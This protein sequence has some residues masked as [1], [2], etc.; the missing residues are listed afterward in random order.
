MDARSQGKSPTGS[1]DRSADGR[2]V[3]VFVCAVAERQTWHFF[4]STPG[5][6]R[7]EALEP[8]A[9]WEEKSSGTVL[10][11]GTSLH[12]G[13]WPVPRARAVAETTVVRRAAAAPPA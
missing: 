3:V 13:D 6:G 4:C 1:S 8:A 12:G 10:A 2:W 5:A 7:P 9:R 11:A